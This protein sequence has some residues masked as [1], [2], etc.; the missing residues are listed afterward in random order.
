MNKT[1]IIIGVVLIL[2]VGGYFIGVNFKSN[3][4]TSPN[5]LIESSVSVQ[6]ERKAE[7]YGKIKSI[8]GNEITITKSDQSVDPTINMSPEEKKSLYAKFR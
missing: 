4:A 7:V 2:A 6:P 1:I 5:L 8:V 3:E